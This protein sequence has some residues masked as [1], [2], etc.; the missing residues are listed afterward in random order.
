MVNSNKE[1]FKTSASSNENKKR[2]DQKW[3]TILHS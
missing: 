2:T 3:L 1:D